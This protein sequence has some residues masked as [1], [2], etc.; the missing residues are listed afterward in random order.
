MKRQIRLRVFETNSSS[1]HSIT[2]SARQPDEH[3]DSIHFECGEFGWETETY[4]HFMD[5]AS[6][7]WTAV[8]HIFGEWVG[9]KE[10]YYKLEGKE[11]EEVR[12]KIR[13]ACIDFGVKN[14]TFQETFRKVGFSDNGGY[15]D[16]TPD[17]D[18]VDELVN[19]EDRLQRYLFSDDSCVATGNDNDYDGECHPESI[20][21]EEEWEYFKG[22]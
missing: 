8:V 13:K 18:F 21:Q 22:N 1:L 5:K 17:R 19:N 12:E 16:H 9:E 7:L 15:I 4:T 14:V 10:G 2:V 11:Y 6:Y 3:P 20:T